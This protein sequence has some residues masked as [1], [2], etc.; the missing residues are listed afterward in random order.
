MKIEGVFIRSHYHKDFK[1][2][3]EFRVVGESKKNK[4]GN[5]LFDADGFVDGVLKFK[6]VA[7]FNE[8]KQ[9]QGFQKIKDIFDR[10]W[11]VEN[12]LDIIKQYE[13][14]ELT[15]R[16]LHYQLVGRGMI[17]HLRLYKRAVS[18]MIDAR[19]NGLVDYDTFSDHDREMIGSTQYEE[20]NVDEAITEAKRQIG[21]WMNNFN[22]HRW[23]NQKF[24]IEVFIEKKALIGAFQKVCRNNRVALGAC[25]GYPSL[26]F[27]NDTANRFID[28]ESEG[29]ELVIL[30]F[31]DYDPSGEDIPRS[32]EENLLN[33]FNVEV[34]VHRVAL[35][36]D[37]VVK[38]K[39]PSA[40][41]KPGDSRSGNWDGIG[42]VEL[43]AVPVQKI[44]E[45][46]QQAI[47][48]YF[49]E[50]LKREL[51]E[52]QLEESKKYK[53]ELKDFVNNLKDE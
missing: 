9:F 42:Q 1:T 5:Y 51:D 44:K 15:L 8:V 46:T 26:T 19:R 11:L 12:S 4:K 27:L 16:G 37:Q 43:D 22:K 40:P 30:Y 35:M 14:G 7:V 18:A 36:E 24:Y 32:I 28:A 31:G 17:N 48:Q 47:D 38:W 20:T 50:D 53:S 21:L 2:E 33:D 39:L 45:L 34:K 49:D 13:P 23:E 6:A 10:E 29:K 25:K 41:I 3:I 52:I